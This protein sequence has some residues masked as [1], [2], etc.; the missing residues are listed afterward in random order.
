MARLKCLSLFS[1][2]VLD[3]AG[4]DLYG[5]DVGDALILSDVE[6][7]IQENA[8]NIQRV[9]YDQAEFLGDRPSKKIMACRIVGPLAS[10]QAIAAAPG[11]LALVKDMAVLKTEIL[12]F[13]EAVGISKARARQLFD[14]DGDVLHE[15]VRNWLIPNIGR[16]LD[17]L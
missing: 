5:F 10:L 9:R 1:R 16:E 4:A 8:L 6:K 11:V 15:R 13:I 3:Q 14:N 12:D 17:A 2:V 7:A